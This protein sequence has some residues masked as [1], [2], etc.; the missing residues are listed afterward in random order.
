[1][2]WVLQAHRTAGIL[3]KR[4]MGPCLRGGEKAH[5]VLPPPLL[6]REPGGQRPHPLVTTALV[7]LKVTA[8]LMDL[9]VGFYNATVLAER[10]THPCHSYGK[11]L[12]LVL[13]PPLPH[14]GLGVQYPLQRTVAAVTEPMTLGLCNIA[15]LAKR[16]RRLRHIRGRRLQP[17]L[18]PLPHLGPGV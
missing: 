9:K 15:I 7:E 4:T 11:H 2:R 18:S 5:S 3:A 10:R 1:M 6:R 12:Q 13:F 8:A 17:F 14:L 16:K